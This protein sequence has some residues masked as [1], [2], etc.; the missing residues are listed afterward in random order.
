MCLAVHETT[1]ANFVTGIDEANSDQSLMPL[2]SRERA[3][4]LTCT[5][6]KFDLAEVEVVCSRNFVASTV[7]IVVTVR[8]SWLSNVP[9]S[10]DLSG[11]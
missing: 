6:S 1:P 9:S 10:N 11:W 4:P 8:H 7:M 2:C 3:S 5:S